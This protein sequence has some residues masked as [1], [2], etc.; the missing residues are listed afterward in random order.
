MLAKVQRWGNSLGLRIPKAIAAQASVREGSSVELSV[1]AGAIVIRPPSRRYELAELLAQV[2][3][4]NRHR[5]LATGRPRGREV[6]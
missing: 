5:E 1:T 6:W 4:Q 2:L 3:P